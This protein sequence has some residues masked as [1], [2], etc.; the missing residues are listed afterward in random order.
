MN[1]SSRNQTNLEM[2]FTSVMDIGFVPTNP[3][4]EYENRCTDSECRNYEVQAISWA[5]AEYKNQF[6]RKGTKKQ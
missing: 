3:A 4:V 5:E 1:Q 6:K 2:L